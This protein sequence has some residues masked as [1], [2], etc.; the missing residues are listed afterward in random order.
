[1]TRRRVTEKRYSLYWDWI[2]LRQLSPTHPDAVKEHEMRTMN[3][4]AGMLGSL[5]LAVFLGLAP[6]LCAAP[7]ESQPASY[8]LGIFPYMAP[9]QTI[10][11]YGPVAASMEKALAYP[12]KLESA[13]SFPDFSRALAARAY[14]IALIQPFDYPEVVEKKGYLPLAQM[15]VP[16]VTQFFVRDDSRFR[17]IE[18]LRG[19]TVAMPPAPAAN[20]R[21]ALR[22]LNDNKLIPGR[23]V[24][25]RHFNSHDSCILQVWSG[26]AS[27]CG[28]AK[29]PI[30]VFEQRMQAKLRPIHDT[31]PIPHIMFVASARVSAAQRVA[32][33]QLIIGWSQTEEGR[34]LLK[35]LGF[36]GFVAARPAEYAVMRNYD[37]TPATARAELAG[38]KELVLGVFPFLAARQLAQN[39]APA[40]PALGKAVG[41]PVDLRTAA[42]FDAFSNAMASASYDL[43]VVQPFDYVEATGHGYLPLAGMKDRLQGTFFVLEKKPYK[44]I[45]D[46][47]G[48]VVAM[49]PADSV[50]G[51]LGRHALILAGLT[52]GR[53]VSVEYQKTHDSCLQRVQSGVAAAC[54]TAELTLPML[55]KELT[56]GLRSVGRTENV[57]GVL[58][59]AHQRLPTATR[60]RIQAEILAW[61]DGEEGRRILQSMHF[62]EF[63]PVKTSDY[64]RMPKLEGER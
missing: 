12:V 27:A 48:L 23:D 45:T 6:P 13:P 37:P 54:V 55:P 53:D 35:N 52:P 8:R 43:V 22:A 50:Q 14:D 60:E 11:F 58:F 39:F 51:R 10:E 31:V 64:L 3:R 2:E 36:T 61:K 5:I 9:R 17:S 57:P 38:G 28:T 63:V 42:N 41:A 19:T 46:F 16:L 44:Q 32:L 25:V 1:M 20:S 49:P 59:M 47:R 7:K 62:G 29:P 24:E 30:L 15:D 40:L 26:T 56:Q 33:R 4:A 34:T 18:D 21:M